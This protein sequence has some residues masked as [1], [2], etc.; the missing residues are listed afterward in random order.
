[1]LRIILMIQV[2]VILSKSQRR[3][4]NN[5]FTEINDMMIW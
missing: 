3:R 2:Y 4:A 1:M 5:S